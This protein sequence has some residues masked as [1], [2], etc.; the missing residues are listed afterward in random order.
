[1]NQDVFI[2]EK[3]NKLIPSSS[4]SG[5]AIIKPPTNNDSQRK[6]LR[7]KRECILL[8]M[9][10]CPT[11][12]SRC[13]ENLSRTNRKITKSPTTAP[14]A[15]MSAVGITAWMR[16]ISPSVTIAGAVVKTEVKN[17]P[18]IKLPKKSN[19]RKG[20][21]I[22]IT[23]SVCTRIAAIPKLMAIINTSCNR[24]PSVWFWTPISAVYQEGGALLPCR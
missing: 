21:N 14:T 5:E 12:S 18:A 10:L 9:L 15:P 23:I 11:N 13:S 3:P 8:H 24:E 2:L 22:C 6:S 4:G 17:K 7:L 19:P 20:V 16:A 1:M